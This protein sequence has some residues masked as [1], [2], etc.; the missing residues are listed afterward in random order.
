L[1]EF[2]LNLPCLHLI[3][4]STHAIGWSKGR[5]DEET[6]DKLYKNKKG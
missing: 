5:R 2:I 6:F 4:A 1:G 3:N